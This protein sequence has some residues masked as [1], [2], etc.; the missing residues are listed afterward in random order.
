MYKVVQETGRRLIYAVFERIFVN[1]TEDLQM[2]FIYAETSLG[3]SNVHLSVIRKAMKKYKIN[4]S[5]IVTNLSM[6]RRRLT[7]VEDVEYCCEG[8]DEDYKVSVNDDLETFFEDLQ[9]GKENPAKPL[10]YDPDIFNNMVWTYFL[11]KLTED[12]LILVERKDE[13]FMSTLNGRNWTRHRGMDADVSKAQMAASESNSK[14]V[15]CECYRGT[16]K[17]ENPKFVAGKRFL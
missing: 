6:L 13:H 10:C 8:K 3:Y 9:I 1:K 7:T 17:I 4:K 14:F 16:R 2:H 11:P 12:E 5:V 15:F